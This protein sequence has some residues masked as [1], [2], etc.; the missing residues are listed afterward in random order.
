MIN[1]MIPKKYPVTCHTDHVGQNSTFVAI[2]GFSVDGN[3][4]I[5][6]AIKKGAT[7]IISEQKNPE[8]I[9]LC[10]KLK[11]EFQQVKNARLELARQSSK[12]LKT[13]NIKTK[14]I[15]IT[16][17]KGK[18]TTTYIVEHI[19]RTA[20]FKTALIGTIKNKI[21]DKEVDSINTTPESDF[22]HMFLH[23]CNKKDVDYLVMEVSSH[24]L[25]LDR[26]YGIKFDS[27]G[28]TNLA[29]EHLDFYKTMQKYF[30]AKFKIFKQVKKSEENTPLRPGGYEGQASVETF[31]VDGHIIINKDND[32]GKKATELL[33]NKNNIIPLEEKNFEQIKEQIPEHMP[34]KFNIYNF[35]M[36]FLIC[37]KLGI[38]TKTIKLAIRN[39]PGVPGRLQKH[40]LKNKAIAFVDY[41]HNPSSMEEVLKTLRSLTK[42]LIV[43]FGCGGDRD[44]TKRP[45]MG[46]ISTKYADKV[47]ITNDNPRFENTRDIIKD[48][49]TG[50]SDK[51]RKNTPSRRQPVLQSHL[52]VGGRLW[53]ARR[54]WKHLMF[55][56]K[57]Q[58][59]EDRKSAIK[60]AAQI[61]TKN[62]I[63][64]IL[65]KGHENYNL[66]KGKKYF[67]D[68]F[69]Q[70][71]NY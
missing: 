4:Y 62:S 63:I 2:K 54:V 9:K 10:Q 23:Q 11:I 14:I 66:I 44:K 68:D 56:N 24:A 28:F 64:A 31:N 7:K 43:V 22:L 47:I 45:I 48:I 29:S 32:W 27:I 3:K 53:R 71:K 67:F 49:V 17:T 50:I 1:N 36:A 55:M 18:T 69:S 13:K 35:T 33:K 51:N 65:G 46:E 58:I 20:G 30:H 40:I 52:G 70:I 61:S 15:G 26:T 34:G 42:D 5:K 21:L 41:A 6:D 37:K 16:G 8:I 57:I 25:S 59:I 39:F 60:Q 38:P 19:L 12:A